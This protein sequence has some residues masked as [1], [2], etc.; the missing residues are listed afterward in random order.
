M[1]TIKQIAKWIEAS[2]KRIDNFERKISMYQERRDKNIAAANKKFGTD[3]KVDDIISK[4]CG[5]ARYQWH[6]YLMPKSIEEI[7]GFDTSYKI[8]SAYD[9]MEENI[10]NRR[11]E[12]ANLERMQAELAELEAKAKADADSYNNGLDTA[13]RAAMADFR[14]VWMEH[15]IEWHGKH[16]EYIKERTPK[17][18][19][20]RNHVRRLQQYFDAYHRRKTHRRIS[21]FLERIANNCNEVINDEVN[22]Y[23]SQYDYLTA[24]KR[25]LEK[26]WEAGIV[27]LTKKCQGLGVDESKVSTGT[28]AMTSRGFEVVIKDGKPRVIYAR[29]IWAAEYSNIVEPHIRYIVTERKQRTVIPLKLR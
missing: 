3:I 11:I 4:V 18:A 25:D 12:Q 10:K 17:M 21:L 24:V 20:L 15:M 9:S 1:T 2:K 23:A 29:I 8:T 14:T 7:I 6:E 13:L 26:S 19:N 28:P 22:K 5:N 16:Y 27:K